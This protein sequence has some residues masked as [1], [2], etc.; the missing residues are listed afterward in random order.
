MKEITRYFLTKELKRKIELYSVKHSE[1]VSSI[2]EK[3]FQW[4]LENPEKV[5]WKRIS[6]A[7][8]V[9]CCVCINSDLLDK[10]RDLRH[11][12]WHPSLRWLF[13]YLWTEEL[14]NNA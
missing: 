1:S 6:S 11:N 4:Y 14:E 5:K 8:E 7:N 10:V 3:L 9:A 12:Y 13:V 2:T